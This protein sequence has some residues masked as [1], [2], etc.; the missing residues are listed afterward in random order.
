VRASVRVEFDFPD[1]LRR[2]EQSFDRIKIAVASTVQ[3]Q[4]GLRFDREGAHNNHDAWAPLVMR[5]GMIL[6][7]TGTMRKSIAPPGADGNPGPQGFVEARGLP[8]DMLVEVGTKV[9]YASTH[10]NGAVIKPVNKRAL[11]YMNPATGKYVFSGKS[12][13]PKRNFTD[14]NET[15]RQEMEETLTNLV[16]DILEGPV[17]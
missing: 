11:R 13:I 12:V 6:S 14:M 1:V 8:S 16:R 10:N 7:L 2:F 17:A 4:V 15:D 9:L 5:D 3:T